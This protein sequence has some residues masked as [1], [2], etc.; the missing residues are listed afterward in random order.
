MCDTLMPDGTRCP[1]PPKWKTTIRRQGTEDIRILDC[2]KHMAAKWGK[3]AS[4][5]T[6]EVV[7]TVKKL[8]R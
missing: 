2:E 7:V 8:G 5:A 1:N 4:E 6:T 3:E